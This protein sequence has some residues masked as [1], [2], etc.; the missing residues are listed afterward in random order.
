M[1]PDDF[2]SFFKGRNILTFFFPAYIYLFK[3]NNRQTGFKNV[4]S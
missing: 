3:V 1:M 2:V 4:Q